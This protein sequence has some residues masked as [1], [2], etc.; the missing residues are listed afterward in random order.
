VARSAGVVSWA[1]IFTGLLWRLRPIG[2]ALRAA[3]AAPRRR[4]RG[5][6][7]MAQPPLLCEEGIITQ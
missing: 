5:I 2:L 3:P 4:L 7:L 1:E 6:L